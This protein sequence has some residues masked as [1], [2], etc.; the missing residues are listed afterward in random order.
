MNEEEVIFRVKEFFEENG[1][2]VTSEAPVSSFFVDLLAV[3]DRKKF[4]V[5]CRGANYLRPHEIHV[6]IGQIV[7][8]MIRIESGIHYC[9][10]MPLS[11][12]TEFKTFGVEGIKALGLTL[13]IVLDTGIWEGTVC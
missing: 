12:A 10:A 7:S 6:M 8:E 1:F 4:F 9:L 11:L 3:K 5:E 2:K 13:L